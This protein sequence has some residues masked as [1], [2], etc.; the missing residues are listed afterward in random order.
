MAP[1][2]PWDFTLFTPP[3]IS[4][5]HAGQTVLTTVTVCKRSI[6]P[7]LMDATAASFLSNQLLLF[8]F[9]PRCVGEHNAAVACSIDK[10]QPRTAVFS[11]TPHSGAALAPFPLD[12]LSPI[13]RPCHPT[14]RVAHG[15]VSCGRCVTQVSKGSGCR[16]S[17]SPPH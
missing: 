13:P 5:F 1:A 8:P 4:L 9:E 7:L 17:S 12:A 3:F 2:S 10:G 6:V 11:R 16:S 15:A 14:A